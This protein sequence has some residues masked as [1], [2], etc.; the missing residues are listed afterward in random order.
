MR[1]DLQG[2]DW[3]PLS[4]QIEADGRALLGS[5]LTAAE[6]RTLIKLYDD[7][8]RFRTRVDMGRHAFGEGDYA[9][10]SEPL[11]ALVQSL[12]TRLYAELAP[13]ANRMM[14]RLGRSQRYPATLDAYRKICHRSGQ[15]KPTPLLLRYRAGGYNRLHR[16]LYGELRFPLQATILLSRPGADFEGGEFLLVENRPREQAIGTAVAL[17]RGQMIV[18]PVH[19]RPAAGKRGSMRVEVRHGVSRILRGERFALGIILH[20]AA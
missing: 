20:D 7:D 6:C 17:E 1:S 18:F 12:R 13:V 3:T 15:S 4:R 11:P 5:V 9:Y 14:E 8:S 2:R 10:F 16:D 19:E